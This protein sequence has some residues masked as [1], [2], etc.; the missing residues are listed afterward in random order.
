MPIRL[1]YLTSETCPTF[2]ADVSLL[3]G[4]WLPRFGV[5][6]DVVA[7]RSPGHVG[8]VQW[9]GG[10]TFLRDVSGG[11][12]KQHLQTLPHCIRSLLR[13]E[14]SRYQAIQVRDRP[15]LA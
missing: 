7:G 1:L 5:S 8:E 14:G 11:E 13:A 10:A 15:V 2:R 4:K 6:S 9:G 12:S 3:F